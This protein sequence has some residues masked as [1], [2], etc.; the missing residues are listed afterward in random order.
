M[1][2]RRATR[3]D[4]EFLDRIGRG[5]SSVVYRCRRKADGNIYCVKEIDIAAVTPEEEEEALKEVHLLASFDH[6]YVI[7]YYDS[8]VDDEL[9]HI[10]MEFAR[11]G[12]LVDRIKTQ[13]GVPLAESQ[14]WRWSLHILVGLH[15]MHERKIL[16]RDLKSANI[17]IADNG[18]AKIGDLGV[19]R[20]LATHQQ[21]AH[22][23]VGTP[24]YLSPELCEG[25]PYNEKSDV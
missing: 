6:P 16:H 1:T 22:T 4:F 9:L 17:F 25:R 8:F 13:G 21:M 2:E 23:I 12:T 5:A 15:H 19:S 24:Y 7:K 3:N 14:I 20:M 18:D 11:H 10:V